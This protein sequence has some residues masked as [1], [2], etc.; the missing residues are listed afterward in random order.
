ME[1]LRVTPFRDAE[2]LIEMMRKAKEKRYPVDLTTRDALHKAL[3][4]RI[5][6]EAVRAA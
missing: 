2:S 4:D 5:I 3:R 1:I 6:K